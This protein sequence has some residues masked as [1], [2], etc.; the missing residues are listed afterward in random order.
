[1]YPSSPCCV[2]SCSLAYHTSLPVTF[3][4]HEA[5]SLLHSLL[6]SCPP[7][8]LWEFS[9]FLLFLYPSRRP[10]LLWRSPSTSFSIGIF[11]SF[12]L[13]IV[14][15]Q[16][17]SYIAY[18]KIGGICTCPAFTYERRFHLQILEIPS[19]TFALYSVNNTV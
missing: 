3:M 6:L 2:S 8:V 5:S 13:L 17:D 15:L 7:P 14:Y 19:Q 10:L 9:V 4:N 1:M 12:P 16:N 11:K 18:K